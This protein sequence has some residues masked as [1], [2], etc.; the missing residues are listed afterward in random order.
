MVYVTKKKYPIKALKIGG[1]YTEDT[2]MKK[3]DKPN[4]STEKKLLANQ[5]SMETKLKK[6][7]DFKI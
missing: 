1:A 7:I 5:E 6:F 4:P 2:V 3:V